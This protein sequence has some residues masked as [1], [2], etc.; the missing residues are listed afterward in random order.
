MGSSTGQVNHDMLI[1]NTLHLPSTSL[2][3]EIYTATME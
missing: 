1:G 3:P 2:H